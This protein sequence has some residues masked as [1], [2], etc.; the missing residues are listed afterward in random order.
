MFRRIEP[1]AVYMVHRLQVVQ[2][3]AIGIRFDGLEYI[4]VPD[5]R[6]G[7]ATAM[8][9]E[10]VFFSEHE[11]RERCIKFLK[12]R[13]MIEETRY[14]RARVAAGF[15]TEIIDVDYREIAPDAG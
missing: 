6:S 10:D 7:Q 5:L 9:D 1:V 12:M 15:D 2:A 11:A 8:S 4:V 3:F 13:L 14:D